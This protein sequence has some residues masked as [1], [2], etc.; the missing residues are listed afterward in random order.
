MAEHVLTEDGQPVV[1]LDMS[2][3]RRGRTYVI[4][5]VVTEVA[6]IHH[7]TAGEAPVKGLRTE[8][9]ALEEKEDGD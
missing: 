4:D 7:A 2:G 1:E 5:G 8:G 9:R 3:T 6:M